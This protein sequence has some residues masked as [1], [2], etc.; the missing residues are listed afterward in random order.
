MAADDIVTFL[1]RFQREVV[2]HVTEG[3]GSLRDEMA[4]LRGEMMERH[5]EVLFHFDSMY[6]RFDR[7]EEE[8]TGKSTPEGT[9]IIE[10][11]F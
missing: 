2:S 8:Y 7:L 11:T 5:R 6:A 1:Q 10:R 3:I 4:K 9:I